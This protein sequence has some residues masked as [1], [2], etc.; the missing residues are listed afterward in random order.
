[1]FPLKM[2]LSN[3]KK[4]WI[5]LCD[6]EILSAKEHVNSCKYNV[7]HK[8]TSINKETNAIYKDKLLFFCYSAISSKF[9][10][11]CKM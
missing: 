5:I 2:Y 7:N 6:W 9:V 3:I 8:Y 11:L 1:M 4:V 10:T